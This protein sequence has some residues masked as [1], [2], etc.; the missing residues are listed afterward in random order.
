MLKKISEKINKSYENEKQSRDIVF[1][2]LNILIMAASCIMTVVNIATREDG[3][4]IATG[5]FALLCFL[6]YLLVKINIL[7]LNIS[8]AVFTVEAMLLLIFFIVSG[9]PEGFSVLWTLLVPAISMYAMGKKIGFFFS[10]V[11]LLLII[12][13]F[14]VPF[15]REL[16][17]YEYS[18]TFMLRFPFV[19]I[20]LFATAAYIDIVL[21]GI[22]DK[23]KETEERARYLYRHD[24]LTGIYSRHA[25]YE[26]LEK[27]LK[28]PSDMPVSLALM[29]IDG[30][31]EINDKYG[32]NAGD[33][34]LKELSCIILENVCEH[35][36]VCRWGGEEFVLFSRCGHDLYLICE[37]IR[38][39]IEKA[40][41]IY[42]D[43][44]LYVTL[45]IGIAVAESINE[46]Q[47]NDFINCADTAMYISKKD[48]KNK[49]TVRN[50]AVAEN[51]KILEK[52]T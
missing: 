45:S 51:L 19:Y 22:Y 44:E 41:V 42:E 27:I 48:G 8:V 4:A 2:A 14:W 36:I 15:G 25:F 1:N 7:K 21:T 26:E 33:E 34:I 17:Q 39:I 9:T 20:S 37:E 38:R 46:L 10:I 23:L 18:E 13:F 29:D 50:F 28:A 16:L 24:A 12:F 32:H 11:T 3:L 6:N 30:F 40:A 43:T 49:T 31:K 52:N 47:L 35:G 5:L